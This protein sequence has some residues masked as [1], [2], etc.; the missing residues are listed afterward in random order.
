VWPEEWNPDHPDFDLEKV[1]MFPITVDG[2]HCKIHEPRHPTLSKDPTHLSH[3]FGSAGLMYE[4]ACS[5][6]HSSI[7]HV[8]GPYPASQHDITVFRNGGLKTKLKKL[9]DRKA[10][11]DSG[12]VGESGKTCSL[13][14]TQ[15]TEEVRR[16]KSRAK[17]RQESLNSRIKTFNI[18]KHDFRHGTEKHKIAFE[19]VIVMLQ[20]QLE[21]SNPLFEV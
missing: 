11:A 16:L 9:Y 18:M 10:I 19:A 6:Y 5:V 3:K 7:V 12:Y 15:D 1:P 8:N 20:Y 2:T 17:A 14:T 21:D 13:Q 4:I